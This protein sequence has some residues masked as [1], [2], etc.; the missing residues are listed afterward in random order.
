MV[1]PGAAVEL[2]TDAGGTVRHVRPVAGGAAGL[3]AVAALRKSHQ[4]V[5]ARMAK[6]RT[7]LRERLR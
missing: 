2:V 7:Q 6:E 1:A 3:G 4:E 5:S